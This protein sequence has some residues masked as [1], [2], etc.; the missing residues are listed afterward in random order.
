MHRQTDRPAASRR[1]KASLRLA[2]LLLFIATGP[3]SG[4]AQTPAPAWRGVLQDEAGHPIAQA[5]VKLEAGDDQKTAT[6]APNGAFVF[7]SLPAK[8]YSLSIEVNGHISRSAA[9]I[10]ILAQAAAVTLTL[11][12]GGVLLVG[13]QQEKAGSGGEQLTSKAVS[14]IPLNK[15][16]FSQLLL[17]AAGTAAD[18]SGASNFTQQ[19]AIN[20][21][22]G[23][24]AVFALDG[25]DISDPELGGGTFTNFNVDAIL[26]LQS[27]SGVMPAEIGRGASGFTNILTRSGTDGI[28]GSVFEFLR[29]SSLDARN[30]FDYSSPANP[31][32]L[33]P[34]RRNEFGFTNGGP[35]FIPHVYDGR[36]KAFYFVEYQGFRQ[37]LGTTQVFAVPT[38]QQRNGIDTTAYA[39]DTLTVPVDSPIAKVLARYPLPN[40]AQ[41]TFGANTYATSSKVTTDADQFSIR[42]DDQL[43]AKDHIFGRFTLD[44]LNGPT[45]NPDQT[46]IDPSFGVVYIDSQRNGVVTWVHTASSRLAFESSLSATRTTPSF[47]TTDQTD[48]AIKFND[49]LFEPFNAPGGSVTR[50][51]GNLFQ[52]RENV[53]VTTSAH[54]F[55]VGAEVRLNRDTTYFGISP[56]GEYDFGGGTAYSPTEIKSQSGLHDIHVGD[57]LPDTLSALLTGSPFA[58]TRAVAPSYFS[59]GQNI[60]PAAD[61][62]SAFAAYVQDV[63][64]ITPRIVLNFGLRFELYT[65]ISERARRTSGFYPTANGGQ[66]FLINPQPAYRTAMN[67]WGPRAQIDY[68][69][70]D[71]LV[72][73]AG[74][75][76]TTIPPNI[77]QDNQLTG[78]LPFVFYPR[79]T[80]APGTQI[81]YG[82]QITPAQLPRVYTP[83]GVDI[84][85]S[86]RPNDV[87]ANTVLDIARLEGDIASL[88]GQPSPL[89]VQAISRGFGNAML[90]TWSLGL[91]RSLG[92]VTTSMTYVGTTA[93]KLARNTFPNAYPGATPAF[94]R[95]TQFNATGVPVG[96]FG[97]ESEITPTSHSSYNALQ[98]SAAGQTPHGGPGMQASYTWS[99]SIDDTSTVAGTSATSTVGAI[100]QAAPQNPFDT[101]SERGPSTFDA[102]HSF[103]L[104]LAQEIPIQTLSFLDRVN[105]KVVEGWQLISI[106]SISSGTPFTVYS[107]IQ[108]TGAGSANSDRPDQIAKPA[109]STARTRREDYFG[110]GANN[111]SFFS[112]PINVSGGTGP[113]QGRFGLLG[114]NSF[115]G[116]AFYDFDISL[117][118]TTPI[119]KRKSGSEL[120][121]VQ[122]RSEFFNIFN[123]VDMGLPSNT[124]LGSGFGLINR[125]AGSSRQIQFS[126][127]VAY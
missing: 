85:A 13:I 119:G 10:T 89:N 120:V 69:F 19:F 54:A 71:H 1:V 88:S 104:S 124:I 52:A 77:W 24:E 18:S 9:A 35:I 51:F 117:V 44:N 55:K 72:G 21:Q 68:R 93:Y 67:N 7:P 22:R 64:K 110:R 60:G 38:Q 43:G 3:A 25:A 118:K 121:D 80:A 39:G 98:L 86:G 105:R 100:A 96:G 127:K 47:P 91:E 81:P 125:T 32:R 103:S 53:S 126:L 76:L 2:F 112:I 99:K 42:L 50:A 46:A 56:N 63:W 33:P 61:S 12:A 28:H 23:V 15:R 65:P 97:T 114:R 31:G 36:G 70:S 14:E 17:L 58:Y 78:A 107:G 30:Y 123:I 57:P 84:F 41:G 92:N 79:V 116:P 34:F 109:L 90:G 29:N 102:T 106:S 48:P 108:Q 74:G 82:F 62:R 5:Q 37:V 40:F 27:L 111:A 66:E 59:N 26:E 20:G 115:R 45:T 95:F 73:H 113:N 87:P 75:A 6:T 122:F 83:A 16:D 11:K 8:S 94:A 4:W 101:H 49:A